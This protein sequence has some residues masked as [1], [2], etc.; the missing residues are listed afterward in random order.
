VENFDNPADLKTVHLSME[1]VALKNARPEAPLVPFFYVLV[2]GDR[3]NIRI[4]VAPSSPSLVYLNQSL[5]AGLIL[6][7]SLYF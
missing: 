3:Y 4:D 6:D 5:V 2:Q 1:V 7:E